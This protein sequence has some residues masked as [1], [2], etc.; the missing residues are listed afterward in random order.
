MI[1]YL[2]VNYLKSQLE[3]FDANFQTRFYKTSEI[4]FIIAREILVSDLYDYFCLNNK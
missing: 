1:N 3:V 2:A 4:R